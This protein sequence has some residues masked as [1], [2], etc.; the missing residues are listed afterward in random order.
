MERLTDDWRIIHTILRGTL[1]LPLHTETSPSRLLV[2]NL[3][4][5]CLSHTWFDIRSAQ[6][7]YIS[8]ARLHGHNSY[9]W[10]TASAVHLRET[11]LF[12][13]RID[14]VRWMI[15]YGFLRNMIII[16]S[17]SDLIR[18]LSIAAFETA[19]LNVEHTLV[20]LFQ[21]DDSIRI[22][23][24]AEFIYTSNANVNC[25][26]DCKDKWNHSRSSIHWTIIRTPRQAQCSFLFDSDLRHHVSAEWL[27][28]IG[29]NQ[30]IQIVRS[31]FRRRSNG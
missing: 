7:R 18:W 1:M 11:P 12:F 21:I 10:I 28:A 26:C 15:E 29:T 23:A 13:K 5:F 30:N 20:K 16:D 17:E 19:F 14:H 9:K 3:R 24:E 22:K 2:P 27:C 6:S 25:E 4:Y 31:E 8:R